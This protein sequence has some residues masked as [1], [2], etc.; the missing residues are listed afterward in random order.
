VQIPKPK[1]LQTQ[2]FS[3]F[4]LLSCPGDRENSEAG[5]SEQ[6]LQAE[7]ARSTLMLILAQGST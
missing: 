5:V 4:R 1:H 6:A 3:N 2:V 7:M